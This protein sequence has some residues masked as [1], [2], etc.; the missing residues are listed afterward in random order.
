MFQLLKFGLISSCQPK[1]PTGIHPLDNYTFILRFDF[2]SL[3]DNGYQLSPRDEARLN[4]LVNMETY[5]FDRRNSRMARYDTIPFIGDV[6]EA[7]EEL[8]A[9]AWETLTNNPA[10]WLKVKLYY[11]G[12]LLSAYY[13]GQLEQIPEKND[14]PPPELA[15][16]YDFSQIRSLDTFGS[17]LLRLSGYVPAGGSFKLGFLFWSFWPDVRLLVALNLLLCWKPLRCGLPYVLDIR[18]GDPV[19]LVTNGHRSSSEPISLL[20]RFEPC[21]WALRSLAFAGRSR[22]KTRKA[23]SKSLRLNR[24]DSKNLDPSEIPKQAR[25]RV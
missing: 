10:R 15:R 21:D 3:L 12:A 25:L 7:N 5:R 13:T 11:F 19:A 14:R 6:H 23:F 20:R 22:G 8:S 18:S 2:F 24:S 16:R 9:L 4:A 17:S 1:F